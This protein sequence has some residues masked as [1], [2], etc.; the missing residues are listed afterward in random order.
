MGKKPE[1]PKPISCSIA[2]KATWVGEVEATDEREAI[3]EA[4][5]EFRYHA[6]GAGPREERGDILR[7][8]SRK[9]QRR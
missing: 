5:T 9:T 4:A 3:E 8:P 6:A 2:A 1:P 7:C